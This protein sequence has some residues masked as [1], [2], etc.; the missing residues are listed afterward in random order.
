M[1]D[2]ESTDAR[3][4]LPLAGLIAVE[5]GDSASAPFAGQILAGLGV[6]VWKVERPVTGDSTRSWG[7]KSCK[8]SA[9]AFHALNR[10]KKSLCLDIKDGADLAALHEFIVARA[11][12]F[13]HNLRPGSAARYGLDPASLRE[14]KPGLVCCE[15]GAYGHVGAMNRLPGYDPLMQAFAGIMSVTGEEGRQPVRA[16]VSVNDSGTGMWAVIGILAALATRARTGTGATVNSSLLETAISWM[17]TNIACL[18]ADGD[19]GRRYGSGT[20]TVV[21]HRAYAAADGHIAV[22]CANDRLFAKLSDVLGHPQWAR[23]PRFATNPARIENRAAIDGLIETQLARASREH[24]QARLAAVG[25]ASAPV[26]TTS[27]IV[28]HAQTAALQILQSPAADELALVGLPLS[29]DG[30]R[31]PP[32]SAA[33][34]LGEHNALLRAALLPI[35]IQETQ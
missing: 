22:S 28:A 21:P 25:V 9:A 32:L 2:P 8:G 6:E 15:I 35:K 12:I 23:D 24:W 3:T 11:D 5:V 20:A 34:R 31:P 27:E 13:L 7:P 19:P 29:F 30:R 18:A 26:Q 1:H 16:G 17:S 14:G 10:G 33:P 4:T